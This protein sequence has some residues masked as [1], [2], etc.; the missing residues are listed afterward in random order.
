MN[1][2]YFPF[3][4]G[5]LTAWM[6]VDEMAG[7]YTNL[8]DTIRWELGGDV[9]RPVLH[10]AIHFLVERH[11]ALRTT[12]VFGPAGH[13]L[14]RVHPAADLVV[15]TL[16]AVECP[17]SPEGSGPDGAPARSPRTGWDLRDRW[18]AR[19][20]I[21]SRT[22]EAH[23]VLCRIHHRVAGRHARVVLAGELNVAV[24]N[25]TAGRPVGQGLPDAVTPR[26]LGDAERSARGRR[27]AAGLRRRIRDQLARLPSTPIPL[28]ITRPVGPGT[29][30]VESDGFHGRIATEQLGDAVRRVATEARVPPSAVLLSATTLALRRTLPALLPFCWRVFSDR[31]RDPRRAAVCYSPGDFLV[32]VPVGDR[33]ELPAVAPATWRQMLAGLRHQV[34]GD[35]VLIEETRRESRRRG[36]RMDLPFWFNFV[37]RDGR[38][39]AEAAA[40]DAGADDVVTVSRFPAYPGRH[41][42]FQVSWAPP[43]LLIDVYAHSFLVGDDDEVV[44]RLLR[45]IVTVLDGSPP[46]AG[47]TASRHPRGTVS[48][49][50]PLS[51]G[52]W[53]DP[54]VTRRVLASMDGVRRAD[55]TVVPGAGAGA[56]RL[57]A[58][59]VTAAGHRGT[60]WR[61]AALRRLD[62]PGFVVPDCFLVEPGPDDGRTMPL[63]EPDNPLRQE[64]LAD[65]VDVLTRVRGRAEPVASYQNLHELGIPVGRSPGILQLLYDRGWRGLT[66]QEIVSHRTVGDLAAMMRRRHPPDDP[67]ALISR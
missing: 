21:C 30:V 26:D 54:A 14:Q 8:V 1:V 53:A 29:A 7:P 44:Q 41:F 52:R 3:T 2:D 38:E 57:V 34:P 59:M 46:R 51:G 64:A 6:T 5:Q 50:V 63:R 61:A 66:F 22:G 25:L 42:S 60:D 10:R 17:G 56:D 23:L 19:W 35:L 45:E 40:A 28:D 65:L 32:Q 15:E 67:A 47:S 36:V 24:A 43:R 39:A 58:T 31:S 16:S 18:P 37:T 49:W 62:E 20:T 55:V 48:R 33:D 9:S 4:A 12:F 13:A 27:A 11:P